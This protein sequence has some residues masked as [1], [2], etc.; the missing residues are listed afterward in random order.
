[1]FS[2]EGGAPQKGPVLEEHLPTRDKGPSLGMTAWY[3]GAGLWPSSSGARSECL[4]P[5]CPAV[6]LTWSDHTAS[7]LTSKLSCFGYLS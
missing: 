4:R 7:W 6:F 2:R 5:G 3:Q 1:M